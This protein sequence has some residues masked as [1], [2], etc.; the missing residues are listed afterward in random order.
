MCCDPINADSPVVGVCPDCG[1]DVDADG[2]SVDVCAWSPVICE[3]CGCAPCDES[4]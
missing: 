4:C 1:G 2:D 3:T